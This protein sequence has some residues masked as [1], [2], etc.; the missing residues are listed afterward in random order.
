MTTTS[1]NEVVDVCTARLEATEAMIEMSPDEVTAILLT[2]PTALPGA[3][4]PMTVDGPPPDDVR[5]AL[6]EIQQRSAVAAAA[7]EAR[8]HAITD[9]LRG[10]RRSREYPAETPA[11][12]FID[13]TS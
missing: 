11:P 6:A 8:L 10:L 4:V 5:A 12:Q 3:F 9:E 7:L 2:D 13:R 1:W